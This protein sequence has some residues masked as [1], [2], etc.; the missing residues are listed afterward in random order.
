MNRLP[1]LLAIAILIY[2]CCLKLVLRTPRL[3]FSPL[4]SI[5]IDDPFGPLPLGFSKNDIMFF[6]ISDSQIGLYDRFTK[7]MTLLQIGCGLRS[8]GLKWV[9]PQLNTYMDW[10]P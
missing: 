5:Q 1:W 6:E 4:N 9:Q 8:R 3:S 7:K 2:G 10:R